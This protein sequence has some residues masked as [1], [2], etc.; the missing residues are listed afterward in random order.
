MQ[1]EISAEE[2]LDFSE[3]Y[4]SK[5]AN[6]TA[7]NEI[8]KIGLLNAARSEQKY[9]F[10]FNVETPK[11]KIYHQH[12]SHQCNI[13]AF[14][15][16]L[17]DVLRQ[18][19][20]LNVDG[21]DL[22]AN[23]I[24]FYDKLE[25][26]NAL[27]NELI[28]DNHLD[29]DTIRDKVDWYIGSF[30]T[31]HFCR[32]IVN[33]YGLMLTKNMR[34]VGRNYDDRLTIGLLREKIKSDA[35]KLIDAGIKEK[36]MALKPELMYGVYQFLAK[37]YG[38]PP[39]TFELQGR[40]FTPM[41][42]KEE[43]LGNRLDD[44]VTV[45]QFDKNTL[46]ESYAYVPN[47]YLNNTE[48]ILHSTPKKIKDAI[49]K[50]LISG[51]SVWFS[52]EELAVTDYSEGIL[53]NGLYDFGKLL[54]ILKLDAA[55]KLSLGITGYAHAMCITGALTKNSEAVQFRVDNS[56]GTTGKYDGQMIMTKSFLDSNVITL[57]INKKFLV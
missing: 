2:V 26:A 46:L 56:F 9:R 28:D 57:I 10:R 52:A 43:F 8:R 49:V 35:V 4:R 30:G 20:N 32:E 22:S 27:Y 21:L 19:P 55:Q 23:Y 7:E 5:S 33:K 39:E 17:K 51:V 24:N 14:L 41:S 15:R 18:N 37:I 50:Q 47:I 48:T 29:L 34:E 53:D 3:K 45:T 12:D 11:T 25:K 13:Y 1:S 6:L 54:E 16:V 38:N 42:F 31:F 40:A 44:Y 36:R